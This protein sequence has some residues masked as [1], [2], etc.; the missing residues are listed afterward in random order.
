MDDLLTPEEILAL[1]EEFFGKGSCGSEVDDD[2][3]CWKVAKAQLAKAEKY[4]GERLRQEIL[5]NEVASLANIEQARK[6]EREK[7]KE[8]AITERR[9][10]TTKLKS[11]KMAKPKDLQ[12]QIYCSIKLRVLKELIDQLLRYQ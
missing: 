10:I 5:G 8:W 7:I 3:L 4:Y 6:N 2:D 1:H 12:G 11:L 9:E